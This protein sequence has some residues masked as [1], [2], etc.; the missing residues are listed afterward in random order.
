MAYSNVTVYFLTVSRLKVK[1]E[2]IPF[3]NQFICYKASHSI[4]SY[5][6]L[7]E[8]AYSKITTGGFM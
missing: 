3:C 7:N 4:I 1:R 2:W 6:D 8:I 5:I